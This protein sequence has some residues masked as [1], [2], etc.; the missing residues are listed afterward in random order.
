MYYCYKNNILIF[1]FRVYSRQSSTVYS[2]LHSMNNVVYRCLFTMSYVAMTFRQISFVA[3]NYGQDE[4]SRQSEM[5]TFSIEL[6]IRKLNLSRLFQLLRS[7]QSRPLC[8]PRL[9][10]R[11]WSNKKFIM[12]F[13]VGR[14]VGR[15]G[16]WRVIA[17]NHSDASAARGRWRNGSKT[18]A[19]LIQ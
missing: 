5:T 10:P 12:P 2:T 17:A 1:V 9:R 14:G 6:K 13:I 18:L 8:R 4:F 19:I 16:I 11:V 3:V 7:E 15:D